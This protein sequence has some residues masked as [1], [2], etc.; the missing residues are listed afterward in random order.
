MVKALHV[1][2]EFCY[3]TQHNV[4][5]TQSL[6]ELDNMLQCYHR[7]REIFITTHIWTRFNLPCQHAL[8]HYSKVIHQFGALNGLCSSIT[9]SK[10]IEAVKEPWW[11][12]SHFDVLCQ[13][14]MLAYMV[15]YA[16]LVAWLLI[17]PPR[18]V[19]YSTSK[20]IC[21]L[22]TL[23][24]ASPYLIL[25]ELVSVCRNITVFMSPNTYPVI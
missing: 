23:R 18:C 12:S 24:F 2:L 21:W 14:L 10:H 17:S 4:H 9:E 1:F 6:K 5:D 19:C 7:Y 15:C 8:I 22:M 13:M 20:H 3:I 25:V 16:L 11:W